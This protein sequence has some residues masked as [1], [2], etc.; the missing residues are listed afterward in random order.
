[1]KDEIKKMLAGGGNY[2]GSYNEIKIDCINAEYFSLTALPDM[3]N[4]NKKSDE[5]SSV[6]NSPIT[7]ISEDI[8]PPKLKPVYDKLDKK[9][10][11]MCMAIVLLQQE[12][13]GD[14]YL[15]R[16]DN[17]WWGIYSPLVYDED[18]LKDPGSFYTLMEQIGM[19]YFRVNCTREQMTDITGVFMKDYHVWKVEDFLD[20]YGKRDWAFWH[21]K[22]IALRMSEILKQLHEEIEL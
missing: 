10:R 19:G 5:E 2:I 20:G 12:K 1:M 4:Q 17:D 11:L 6:G 13:E 18:L 7:T 9:H 3:L 21:K 16:Y 8:I 14:K 22:K 15:F